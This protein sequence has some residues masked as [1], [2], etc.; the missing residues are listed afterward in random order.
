MA[1]EWTPEI[2]WIK[3]NYS[4]QSYDLAKRLRIHVFVFLNNEM[5]LQ[6]KVI[7]FSTFITC[8]EFGYV[9]VL[10]LGRETITI[11]MGEVKFHLSQNVEV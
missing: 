1:H 11:T 5:H 9:A 3:L 6:S 7:E 8:M 10:G 2:D 4:R